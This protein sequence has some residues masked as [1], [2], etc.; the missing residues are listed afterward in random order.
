MTSLSSCDVGSWRI[1]SFISCRRASP[2]VMFC[3]WSISVNAWQKSDSSSVFIYARYCVSARYIS[4]PFLY[5]ILIWNFWRR[6]S[7]CCSRF[8]AVCM[9]FCQIISNS[10]WSLSIDTW[11][12][13]TYVLNF[14]QAKAIAGSSLG[15]SRFGTR[16][17]ALSIG[18][19]LPLLHQILRSVALDCN[20][21][22]QIIT[23]GGRACVSFSLLECQLMVWQPI[24]PS[25][26]SVSVP[27]YLSAIPGLFFLSCTFFLFNVKLFCWCLSRS[28]PRWSCAISRLLHCF[29]QTR[30][31]GNCPRSLPL[32]TTF[33]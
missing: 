21:T 18:N 22:L 27:W 3:F 31:R 11:L 4:V 16:Q 8:C 23:G 17:S 14:S 24:P 30:R 26:R 2:T 15:I 29:P 13:Y 28:F 6:S 33:P 7:I 5:W 32:Q 19:Q 25:L 1:A 9:G 20:L 12:P 10:F